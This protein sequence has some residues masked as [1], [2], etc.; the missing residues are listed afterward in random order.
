MIN[1]AI[2]T[3][4][5]VLQSYV[6]GPLVFPRTSGRSGI[7]LWRAGPR[8]CPTRMAVP[9]LERTTHVEVIWRR[10]RARGARHLLSSCDVEPTRPRF[11]H[12]ELL[13]AAP[14]LHPLA[15]GVVPVAPRPRDL[16]A[17][18]PPLHPLAAGVVPPA[19]AAVP[20]AHAPPPLSSSTPRWSEAWRAKTSISR[21]EKSGPPRP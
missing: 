9:F 10:G 2:Q 16:L 20:P 14:P 1:P 12:A 8:R 11:R 7:S 17:A 15:A 18:A 3:S 6:G 21:C 5:V 4:A 13:A 19:A